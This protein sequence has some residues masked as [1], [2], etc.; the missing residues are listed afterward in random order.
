MWMLQ[1]SVWIEHIV[2]RCDVFNPTLL[3]SLNCKAFKAESHFVCKPSEVGNVSAYHWP[4]CTQTW[5]P[6]LRIEGDLVM[7]LHYESSTGR[8]AGGLHGC[9]AVGLY[10]TVPH[11]T[12]RP[13]RGWSAERGYTGYSVLC[14]RANLWSR[15]MCY[16]LLTVGATTLLSDLQ[17]SWKIKH[18]LCGPCGGI[19]LEEGLI[20]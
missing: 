12:P 6:D 13:H 14:C 7:P 1:K 2:G 9:L 16:S 10:H 18:M 8:E 11:E 4:S 3:H 20:Q 15:Q 17:C 5:W 19:I